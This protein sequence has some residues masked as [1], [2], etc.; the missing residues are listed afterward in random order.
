MYRFACIQRLW[1]FVLLLVVAGTPVVAQEPADPGPE[2][3]LSAAAVNPASLT[4]APA[5]ATAQTFEIP[6]RSARPAV[7]MPLYVS[8]ASLQGLDAHSTTRALNRGGEEAN[9]LLR[10]LAGN[11]VGLV[12]VKA[13]ATTGVVYATEKMWKR[14]KAAAI[15]FMVA[16]NS[17]MAWVVQHNYRAVR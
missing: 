8:F 11:P 7:L 16:A 5:A 17:A 12:A 3:V 14:N 9:P 10:G 1:L 13:A 4:V 2:S 6:P 15:V